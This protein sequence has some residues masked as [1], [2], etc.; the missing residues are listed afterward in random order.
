MAKRIKTIPAIEPNA[1]LK[2]ALQKRLI[3][4]IEKQTREATAE[5]LA[6]PDRFGLLHAA[7]R[8][9]CAGRRTVGTQREKDHR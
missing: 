8:D 3:A 6:Q 5:L 4:L 9:G 7:C 1:G 2:A